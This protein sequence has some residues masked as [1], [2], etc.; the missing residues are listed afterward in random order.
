MNNAIKFLEIHYD[1]AIE[2]KNRFKIT[3]K[4]QWN[5]LITLLELNVQIGHLFNI[6]GH[7]KAVDET[8]RNISNLGDELSDVLLQLCYLIHLEN[9]DLKKISKYN[10]SLDDINFLPILCGQLIEAVMEKENYRFSK[11]RFGFKNINSF[12]EDR[13][14]KLLIITINY[15]DKN[16]YNMIYEFGLMKKDANNFLDNYVSEKL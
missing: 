9:V 8:N 3:E 1:G 15:A 4:R 14:F 10:I 16:G 7:N 13:L 5:D 12:I 11:E 6:E 2:L